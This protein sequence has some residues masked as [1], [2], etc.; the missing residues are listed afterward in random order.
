MAS[1]RMRAVATVIRPFFKRGFASEAAG[2][3]MLAR[4]KGSPAP[5]RAV[6]RRH[7]VDRRQVHGRDVYVVRPGRADAAPSA[8]ALVYLHGGAYTNAIVKQHWALIGHLAARTG[9][10][11]HVP[12]YG[13]APAH[14]GLEALGLVTEV[15]AEVSAGG[16]GCYLVGDSAGGGLALLAAQASPGRVAGLT[17]IAPWLDL[18]M[19]NP[20]IAAIEPDDPW[21][22][23]AGLR[24][25]AAAWAHGL[26]LTDPRLS[27]LYGDL[28]RLP[29][30]QVLVGTRDITVADC[31]ALR[32]RMPPGAPLTYHEEPGAIHAY[33]MLPVPEAAVARRAIVGHIRATVTAA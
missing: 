1:W 23:R 9:C 4:P 30:L 22:A 5:T 31:R 27:P 16:H 24:P 26:P 7:R 18:S 10:D 6:T 17:V 2:H 33:P 14:H 29:P 13:L 32:D 11:V 28:E 20:A 25:V 19:S 12:L 21:L 8:R 15:I 3:A